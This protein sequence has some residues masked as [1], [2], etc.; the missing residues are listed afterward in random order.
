MTATD[1]KAPLLE[2]LVWTITGLSLLFFSLRLYIKWK[3]RGKLWYDDYTLAA[4]MVSLD[5]TAVRIPV[6]DFPI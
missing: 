1:T 4:S 5:Q 2:G 3:Y 6:P